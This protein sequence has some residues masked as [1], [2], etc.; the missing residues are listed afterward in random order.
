MKYILFTDIHFGCKSNSDEFNQQCLD[1]LD[2]I[3]D[4]TKDM[5]IDGGIF[6]GDWYHVRSAT[7]TK[8]LK[9]GTEG[10]Y[11]FGQLSRGHGMLILGNHDLYY[12][13]RRDTT[14]I[15][16][17][18]GDIGVEIVDEPLCLK[19]MLYVPWL[20]GDETLSTIIQ[21][22]RP[23]Y[24]FCHPEIPTF[25]LNKLSKFDGEF[26]PI[27]Y[28]GPRRICCGHFHLRQEQGNIT[29]IGNCFS[30]D[31][32]DSN[33]WHN[34]G[35]AILDTETNEIEYYEWDKAPKYCSTFISNLDKIEFGENLSLKLINNTSM[36]QVELNKL[37]EELR[38]IPN[39]KDVIIYPSEMALEN[40]NVDE[41]SLKHCE[42]IDTL[43]A[44]L[45]GSMDMENVSNNELINIYN[46]LEIK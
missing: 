24:V 9:Y 45:I 16:I 7:N 25:S 18:E 41:E 6:L 19:G 32:S 30:H 28:E 12:H 33:E 38:K 26:N 15:I 29:Y 10:L 17:P 21:R 22:H 46:N 40:V 11:K 2:F 5:D 35:F 27:D 36:T 31:F 37:D 8:T 14:P 42:N 39:L 44:E 4:K 34:K 23:Q 3:I 43:I 1:F 13:D 20:V